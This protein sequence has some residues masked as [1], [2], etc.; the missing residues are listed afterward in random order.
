M[1]G[2]GSPQLLRSDSGNPMVRRRG[3]NDSH[4]KHT[5]PGAESEML[6]YAAQERLE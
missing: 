6:A 1:D 5:R 2:D 4:L 3:M